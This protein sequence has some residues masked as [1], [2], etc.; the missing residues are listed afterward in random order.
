MAISRSIAQNH[1]G[2]LRLE[3]QPDGGGASFLLTLPVDLPDDSASRHLNSL[4]K[5]QIAEE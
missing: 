3:P 4:M 1:G 5:N 2:D